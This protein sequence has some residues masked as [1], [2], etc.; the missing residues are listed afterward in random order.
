MRLLNGEASP[1]L[2][3]LDECTHLRGRLAQAFDGDAVDGAG[4]VAVGADGAETLSAED[5]VGDAVDRQF[6]DLPGAARAG[7]R[8]DAKALVQRRRAGIGHHVDVLG[9]AR[10]IGDA[11]GDGATRLGGDLFEQPVLEQP[12]VAARVDEPHR[13]LNSGGRFS[14]KARRPS[15]A[16]SVEKRIEKRSASTM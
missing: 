13:P 8:I 4:E 11:I 7:L 10:E 3:V 16:S 1:E 6:Q 5:V 14:V 2:G 15:F 9:V 12:L